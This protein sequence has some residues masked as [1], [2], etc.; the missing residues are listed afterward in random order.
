NLTNQFVQ[1]AWRVVLW[2]VAYSTVL[3]V[4]VTGKPAS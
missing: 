3:A 4:A 1:P 2:S